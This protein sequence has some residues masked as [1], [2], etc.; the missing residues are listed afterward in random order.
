M[1]T[2]ANNNYLSAPTWQSKHPF[3]KNIAPRCLQ[4]WLMN[5]ESLTHALICACTAQSSNNF[6]VK[7]FKED[8]QKPTP[9]ESI[10]LGLKPNSLAFVRQVHLF[11]GSQAWVYA[12]TVVPDATLH[13]ELQ[14][15][16]HL[17]TQPLGAILFANKHIRRGTIE[18]AKITN[19]H[20]LHKTALMFS[21]QKSDAIW[22]RRSLFRIADKPLMVSEIFLPD[23]TRSDAHSCK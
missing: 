15:L 23:L 4:N 13:G 14:K 3:F 6:A 17:G 16:T 8:W 2:G 18:I 12:R 19:Q 22:G 20:K 11:C 1:N 5:R 7:V 9:N 10:A 21:Q